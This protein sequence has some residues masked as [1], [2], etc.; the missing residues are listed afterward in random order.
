MLI[1]YLAQI[2]DNR[3]AQGQRYK[4]HEILLVSILALLSGATSYRDI[5]RFA[6]GRLKQLKDLLRLNWK[7]APSKSNLRDILCGINKSA[8]ET[9]FRNYSRDLSQKNGETAEN[10]SSLAIDGKALKGSA[11]QVK[12]NAM[13][14]LLSVLCTRTELILG[15]VEIPEKTN[16][17]PMAQ[18]LI[19]ELG[20]PAGSVYTL[21]ALHCQKKHL[22]QSSKP[23]AN[24]LRKSKKTKASYIEKHKKLAG[25]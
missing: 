25:H 16:E 5:T 18:A 24:S 12:G 7:R 19:A 22:K 15:H 8:V 14:H 21:D 4:L 20:L 11:D 6:K 3:R 23:K 2:P 17:I 9:A 13:L 10:I 1:E